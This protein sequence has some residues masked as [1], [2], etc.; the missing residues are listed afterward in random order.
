MHER[1]P[2]SGLLGLIL[3]SST[4]TVMGGAIIGPVVNE[5][6]G[7]LNV[8]ASSAGLIITMHGAFVFLLSPVAGSIIDRVGAKRPLVAG[9]MLYGFAGGAG[10]FVD[11]YAG[12]LLSRALLG[13]AIAFIFTAVTVVILGLYGGMERNRMMGFRASANSLG[14]T[15][16][17]LLGGALGVVSWHLP[18]GVYLAG[19]PLA[20]L[21]RAYM[22]E[23]RSRSTRDAGSLLSVLGRSPALFVV[24]AAMLVTM[25]LL[26]ANIVYIPRLLDQAGISTTFHVGLFLAAMGLAAAITASRYHVIRTHLEYRTMYPVAFSLWVVAFGLIYL[27]PSLPAY[28]IGVALFGIGQ[29]LMLPTAMLWVG[30]LVPPSFRGRFSS[31]ITTFG[32]LGQFLSP[33]VFAPVAAAPD[34]NRV[35]L[36]AAIVAA[37]GLA[38]SLVGVALWRASG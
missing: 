19:I 2:S 4:L 24:Y 9:L 10:L 13:I 7:S 37:A 32:F 17:P 12:L 34:V 18:F 28:G 5:I 21:L 16:W 35:F 14:G 33:I 23:V 15:L 22:P 3:A 26:Y 25:L 20:V 38:L 8:S 29:G 36:A 27:M 6:A 30:D 1:R 31:Y 11:S